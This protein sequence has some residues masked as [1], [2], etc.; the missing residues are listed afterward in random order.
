MGP[1]THR[2]LSGGVSGGMGGYLERDGAGKNLSTGESTDPGWP[3]ARAKCRTTMQDADAP[4]HTYI[5]PALAGG[6][7][8]VH[9][10]LPSRA[11]APARHVSPLDPP[12]APVSGLQTSRFFYMTL[13]DMAVTI[14]APHGKN[15]TQDVY[16]SIYRKRFVCHG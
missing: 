4:Y 8:G 13:Y 15:V 10:R 3:R 9:S 1:P 11:R 16:N 6:G 14:Y 12:A 5:W 2:K 7:V